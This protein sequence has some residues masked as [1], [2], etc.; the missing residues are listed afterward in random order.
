VSLL[1]RN[2]ARGTALKVELLGGSTEQLAEVK[3]ALQALTEPR[4]EVTENTMAASAAQKGTNG[5]AERPDV[6]MVMLG[7]EGGTGLDQL[8][9]YAQ[10]DNR[11]ALFALLP[12]QSPALIRQAL[13]AGA[14]ETLFLPLNPGD[15]TRAMLKV[16]EARRRTEKQTGGNVI[17]VTSLTGG[18]GV[19][20]FTINL[21][22]ALH[23]RFKRRVALIDLDLQTGTLGVMLNVEPEHT[24][25]ELAGADKVVDSI[26]VEAVLAKSASGVY[27]MAAPKHVEQ[28]EM[29]AESTVERVVEVMREMFDFVL[30]DCGNSLSGNV[31]AAW[32]RSDRLF[33]LLDQSIAGARCAFRFIDVFSRLSLTRIKPQFVLSRFTPAYA[34]TAEQV[35]ETL[36]RPIYA[37]IPK[38]A[39]VMERVELAGKDLWQIAP[40][41]A[42]AKSFEELAGRILERPEEVH[43][44]GNGG[45]VVSRLVS[46]IVS[47]AKGANNVAR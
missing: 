19:T 18:I 46:A 2:D 29:I 32:E 21:A 3:A 7:T 39:Q 13:R 16:S 35:S 28:S 27:V 17:S 41:S 10:N 4:L 31:A 23:Y 37:T 11:P 26:Q 38:D 24:I 45:G 47:R 22:F 25:M 5:Y 30:I 36:A 20:S 40:N 15:T 1:S 9:R 34:I 44:T 42:L 8:L 12:E 14:D 43:K 6:V 33:Y